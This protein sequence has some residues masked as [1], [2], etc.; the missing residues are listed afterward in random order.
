M[1]HWMQ[2]RQPRYK[3]KFQGEMERP[4]PSY[5]VDVSTI[6]PPSGGSKGICV[7]IC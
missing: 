6:D 5:I 4:S 2:Y 1:A 7:L 3:A